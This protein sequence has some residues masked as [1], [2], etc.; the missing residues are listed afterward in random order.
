VRIRGWFALL[1]R[2]LRGEVRAAVHE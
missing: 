2:L 1:P